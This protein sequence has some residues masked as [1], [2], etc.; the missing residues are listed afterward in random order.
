MVNVRELLLAP[1]DVINSLAMASSRCSFQHLLCLKNVIVP[2][3]KRWLHSH[4][5]IVSINKLPDQSGPWSI[6]QDI[7]F[8]Q[9][10]RTVSFFSLRP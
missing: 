8:W 4:K 1:L 2:C 5:P 6:L 3:R 9:P 7:I 10:N